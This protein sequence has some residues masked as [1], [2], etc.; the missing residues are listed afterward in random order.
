[1]KLALH[2]RILIGLALGVVVGLILNTLWTPAVWQSLG[3]G[4]KTAFLAG[5]EAPANEAA[6]FA[7]AGARF[8]VQLAGFIGTLFLN[9]L[10]FIAVP[11]VLCV[12]ITGAA[13]LGD[14]RK[15]GRIGVKTVA[16]YALTCVTAISIGLLVAN[17]LKPGSFVSAADRDA[18][19]TSSSTEMTARVQAARQIKGVWQQL[20]EIVPTNPFKALADGNM[21]Q[22]I[23]FA[24]AIGIGL[25]LI[26]SEKSRPVVAFFDA[27]AEVMMR[28]IHIVMWFAPVA[29]F[30][31]IA[32][33]IA[34]LGLGLLVSL[35]A[36]AGTVIL[37][38]ALVLF[39]EYPLV[40]RLLA[41]FPA[42]RFFKA[43][44]PA[45]LVAFSTSSSAATL[46]VTMQ[47][48]NERL[49][50]DPKITS[51]VCPLGAS[52]NMD[53]TALHQ[54]VAVLFIAQM[55]G[56]ELT[57]AQQISM[58]LLATL[59]AIGSPGIPS[60]GI[61]MLIALVQGVGLPPQAIAGVAV[62]MAIDRPLDMCRTVVN[63]AGDGIAA[64]IVGKTEGGLRP[65][66]APA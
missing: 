31:L 54:S 17:T 29:V 45:Q 64:A 18:L 7:A 40:L 11:I 43:M 23:V 53:G 26:P 58:I 60:G 5:A 63:V 34:S 55:F 46:P 2:W 42:S 9:C 22:I 12:L 47:C 28:L 37:G 36:Y 61:V 16:I 66:P 38:L 6:G 21:L 33:L 32:P 35:A 39:V 8:L 25:T 59:S 41:N 10:R 50:V 24:V 14:P 3:V 27:L 13:S 56:Q 48:C 62:V 19:V 15:L 51:F 57:L 20:L 1:M 52:I 44:M 49:G 30:C 65:A 4:D